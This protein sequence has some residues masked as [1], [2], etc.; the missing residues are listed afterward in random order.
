ML[1]P[2][3]EKLTFKLSKRDPQSFK[4]NQVA[5]FANSSKSNEILYH[6]EKIC[7]QGL[8]LIPITYEHFLYSQKHPNKLKVNPLGISGICIYSNYLLIGKRS[9][10]VSTYAN[11][12][13]CVPS[14]SFQEKKVSYNEIEKTLVK[15]FKEEAGLPSSL[16]ERIKPLY[17]FYDDNTRVY[18][19]TFSIIL[20]PQTQM[21][22][23]ANK[24]YSKI[25]WIHTKDLS[26]L[27]KEKIVPLSRLLIN[28]TSSSP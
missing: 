10:G 1:I 25:E 2:F 6:V 5:S 16:I 13:E 18:D 7:S 28:L 27:L 23:R 24:E 21:D 12:W 17:I 15:E 20:K 26:S 22:L 11:F 8:H 9:L 3:S 4:D 14:G 19:L